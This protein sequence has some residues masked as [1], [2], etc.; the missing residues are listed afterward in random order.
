[1]LARATLGYL[2]LFRHRL[3]SVCKVVFLGKRTRDG[4]WTA[5][6]FF[7]EKKFSGRCRES[8]QES[9]WRIEQNKRSPISI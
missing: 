5:Q 3:D 7:S 1:M 6:N 2:V 4:G 9:K 8:R